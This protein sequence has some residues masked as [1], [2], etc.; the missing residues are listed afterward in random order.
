MLSHE[1]FARFFRNR[2]SSRDPQPKKK[3]FQSIRQEFAASLGVMRLEARRVLN[4]AALPTGFVTF[5]MSDIEDSTVLLRKLGDRYGALLH[6]VR[7]MLRTADKNLLYFSYFL[8]FNLLD[9]RYILDWCA[10]SN[11]PQGMVFRTG[12]ESED[13]LTELNSIAA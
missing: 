7:G 5:L 4:A 11:H 10:A 3:H 8:Y 12:R 2:L 13:D 9:G 1:W 6:D